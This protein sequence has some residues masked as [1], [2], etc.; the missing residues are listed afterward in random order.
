MILQILVQ[1]VSAFTQF[2]HLPL[3][4]RNKPKLV[5]NICDFQLLCPPGVFL[6]LLYL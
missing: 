5:N 2:S 6:L 4:H 3:L 1:T